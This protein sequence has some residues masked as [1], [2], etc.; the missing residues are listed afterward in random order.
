M[1]QRWAAFGLALLLA[2]GTALWI[3]WMRYDKLEPQPRATLTPGT[4]VE[5]R[6]LRFTIESFGVV[7]LPE[8]DTYAEVPEGAVW[9]ELVLR[10]EVLAPAADEYEDEWYCTIELITDEGRWQTDTYALSALERRSGCPAGYDQPPF[11]AGDVAQT[12]G[13]WMVPGD[14]LT[15]PRVLIQFT[16]PPAAFEVRPEG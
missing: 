2:V 6:N 3:G 1:K 15:N 9:V 11:A 4:S 16:P 13:L 8:L 14:M 7:D 5:M 12:Y 10:Q